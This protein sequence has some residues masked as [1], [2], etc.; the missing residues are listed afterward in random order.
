MYSRSMAVS[1]LAKNNVFFPGMSILSVMPSS[2]SD[3]IFST[4][5]EIYLL[6]SCVISGLEKWGCGRLTNF[7][8]TKFGLKRV[9]DL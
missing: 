4:L 5:F 7:V 9:N 1:Y 8:E 3:F 6:I 2:V